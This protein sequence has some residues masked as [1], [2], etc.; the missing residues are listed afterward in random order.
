MDAANTERE[1]KQKQRG[2][3]LYLCTDH[4]ALVYIVKNVSEIVSILSSSYFDV[5]KILFID[6]CVFSFLYGWYTFNEEEHTATGRNFC[7]LKCKTRWK[8][9]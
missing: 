8:I 7:L 3:V 9:E 5:K 4:T 6:F 2:D 1:G